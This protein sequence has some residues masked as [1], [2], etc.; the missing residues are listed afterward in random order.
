LAIAKLK[1]DQIVAGIC[2]FVL[3]GI[4]TAGLWP[5]HAARNQAVWLTNGLVL[6][7]HGTALSAAAFTTSGPPEEAGRSVE[8]WLQPAHAE[9]SGTIL[10]FYNPGERQQFSL[11]Q[12]EDDLA[13]Q[14]D[15]K[16]ARWPHDDAKLAY[17]AGVFRPRAPLFITIT[18][19][20][21]GTAAYVDG[22]A[23]KLFRRFRPGNRAFT[24][25]LVI[26]NSPVVND[27][28]SGLLLGLAVYNQE[29]T[30]AQV[31]QHH[32]SWTAKGRPDIR[33]CER[34]AAVYLFNERGGNI[35]HDIVHSPGSSGTDLRIPE[36]YMVLDEKFL[37]PAWKEFHWE[38]DYWKNVLINIG[39]FIPLG[40]FFCA[41]LSARRVQAPALTTIILGAVISLT[42]EVLQAFLPTRDSGT[43]DLI[44]NTLGTC[45]GV[46]FYRWKPT[47]ITQTLHCFPLLERLA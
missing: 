12:S 15:L 25:R 6:G 37:E 35:I 10:A 16:S 22:A 38:W 26:G 36:R 9:D 28:W 2:V 5:F 11:H 24:G 39:G 17:L 33:D 31:R 45:L 1:I 40:F 27:S 47:L 3:A 21:Q 23:V 44:T 29:L 7:R 32:E 18:S 43:T 14:T 46:M 4:L 20:T 8:I 34:S 41:F 19:G 13:L 30:A 42:I